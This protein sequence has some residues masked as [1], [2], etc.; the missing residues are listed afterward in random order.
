MFTTGLLSLLAAASLAQ[1][2]D[3]TATVN[4]AV[5]RGSPYHWASGFIYGIPD[6]P[7]QVPDHWYTDRGF[8]YGRA[9]GAPVPWPA[10]G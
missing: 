3:I 6:T 7:D 2:D 10:G 5:S 9:G 8:R 1:A 4:L